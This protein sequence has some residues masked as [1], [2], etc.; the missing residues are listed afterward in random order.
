MSKVLKSGHLPP[1]LIV[2][3]RWPKP[4][5]ANRVIHF[6]PFVPATNLRRFT[7]SSTARRA[8]YRMFTYVG[9]NDLPHFVLPD[10]RA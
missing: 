2:V 3:F 1:P 5:F 6:Y 10:T 8:N 9:L 7:L 4:T